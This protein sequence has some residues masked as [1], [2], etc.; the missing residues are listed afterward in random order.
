MTR[1]VIGVLLLLTLLVTGIWAAAGLSRQSQ[2]LS[3][4]MDAAAQ[5]ALSEDLQ[6]SQALTEEVRYKWEKSL[7]LHAVFAD[8]NP[9]D[10]I[11]QGFSRLELYQ[12][13]GDQIG[14]ALACGE[15]AEQFRALGD[16]YG[17]QWWNIL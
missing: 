14:C 6:K 7:P 8:H 13:T 12:K 15:L 2:A 1:T 17:A 3:V 9:L 4:Q 11:G 10:A 16:S 5:L